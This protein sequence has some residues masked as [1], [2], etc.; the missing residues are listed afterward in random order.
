[1]RIHYWSEFDRPEM[2]GFLEKAQES[3]FQLV[4]QAEEAPGDLKPWKTLGRKWHESSSGFLG[5]S[6]PAWDMELLRVIVSAL[7]KIVPNAS[8]GWQNKMIVPVTPAGNNRIWARLTT[9]RPNAVYLEL[10]NEKNQFT[11]G[12]VADFGFEP[13]VDGRNPEWD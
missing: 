1:M 6:R 4:Q 11:M 5:N 13:E 8:W 12:R 3:F 9:K 10:F 7:E 2:W